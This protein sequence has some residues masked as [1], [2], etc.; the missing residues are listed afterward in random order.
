MIA[1]ASAFV[2]HVD[3][4]FI[5][6]PV[7]RNFVSFLRRSPLNRAV[8]FDKSVAFRASSSSRS[9]LALPPRRL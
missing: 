7:C 8:P 5:L 6:L 4:V 9:S 3:I 1:R 2:L